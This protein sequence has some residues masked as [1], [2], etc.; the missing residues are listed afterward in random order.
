MAGRIAVGVIRKPHGVRGEASVEL[1]TDSA[2]RLGELD[3]VELLSPDENESRPARIESVRPHVD[4][5]LVKFAG[6]ESPDDLRAVQNWTIEIPE[7]AARQLEEDEYF[8]HDLVGLTLVDE[9]G[10]ER[11]IVRDT[12]EGGGG[13]LLRVEGPRGTFD[14]PFASEIC[15]RIDL[16]AGK[17]IVKLPEGLDDLDHVED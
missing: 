12:E 9:S 1:W 5:A 14:V 10:R 16:S 6:F 7:S 2:D 4:R 15:T 3:E 11:G 13:V 17:I 8:I